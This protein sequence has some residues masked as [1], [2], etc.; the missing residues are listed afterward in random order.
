MTLAVLAAHAGRAREEHLRVAVGVHRLVDRLD[1]RVGVE[2]GP[3]GGEREL[4]ALLVGGFVQARVEHVDAGRLVARLGQ[5]RV[6][7]VVGHA[8][9]AERGRDDLAERRLGQVGGVG[10]ADRAVLD[11]AQAEALAPRRGELLDGAAEHLD[12]P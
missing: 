12:A 6:G 1:P 3:L 8:G 10:V 9:V 5:H 11:D 4:D 7:V 2:S